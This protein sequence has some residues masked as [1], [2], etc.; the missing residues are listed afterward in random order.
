MHRCAAAVAIAE[1]NVVAHANLV[2]VI[3]NRRAGHRHQHGVEQF[4]LPAAVCEQGCEPAP[5]AEI[6]ARVRI[7]R[8]NTPHVIAFFVRHHFQGQLVMITQ[9]HGPLAI[10]RNGGRLV[11]NIDDRKSILHL[12]RHEHAR[13]EGEVKTHVRFVTIS[14]IGDRVFRPLVC[15]GQK[16]PARKLHVDMRP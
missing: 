15:L 16:H 12:Q 8:V 1:I 10:V 7:I 5:N 9:K 4:H 2:A 6:D 14:E 11:E 13:H 3:N